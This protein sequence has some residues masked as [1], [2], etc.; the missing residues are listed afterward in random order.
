MAL[1]QRNPFATRQEQPLFTIGMN[2]TVLVVGLGNVGKE[3]EGTRHNI[4]F[5]CV[6]TFTSSQDFDSWTDKKDLKCLLTS[7]VLG[8]TRV[9]VAK[10]TT[11]MNLSGEAVQKVAHFYKVPAASIIVVHDELDVAF[12]QIRTRVGGGSAGNNGI[13]SLIQQL[14]PDFNRVRVGIDSPAKG[15]TDSADFVLA[16]FS[17][18]EKPHIS[19]IAKEVTSILTEYIFSN[20]LPHDTRQVIDNVQK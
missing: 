2:K 1:F 5:V 18:D 20:Q 11:F 3:Y 8:D 12:G 13:K 10:P 6:D 7:K 4:G 15:K 9:L 17:K 19:T 14:G 16:K